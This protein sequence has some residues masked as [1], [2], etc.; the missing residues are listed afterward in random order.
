MISLSYYKAL[1]CHAKV[2]ATACI[3][4][5]LIGNAVGAGLGQQ[6]FAARADEGG[7]DVGT[8]DDGSTL[9]IAHRGASGYFPEETLEAY[10]LAIAMGVDVIEPDLVVTKDG[11]LVA[12]HDVTLS[13]STDVADHPEFATRKRAGENGDG[14]PVRVRFHTDRAEDTGGQVSQPPGSQGLR[15][16]LSHRDVPGNPGSH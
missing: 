13:A 9:I 4:A 15:R 8:L 10:R 12:R 16:A 7:S 5:V 1:P 3:S 14:E 2:V 11:V 6:T